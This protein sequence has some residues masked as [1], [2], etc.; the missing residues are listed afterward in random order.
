MPEL[1]KSDLLIVLPDEWEGGVIPKQVISNHNLGSSNGGPSIVMPPSG[2]P[3][4][5]VEPSILQ[6]TNFLRA[7][8]EP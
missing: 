7:F 6:K 8:S 2:G 1:N 5:R 4:M 3:K